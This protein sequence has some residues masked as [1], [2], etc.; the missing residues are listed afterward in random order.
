MDLKNW[1]TSL[2]GL[3]MALPQIL[4]LLGMAL[5]T[6]IMQVLTALGALLLYFAKDKNVTGGG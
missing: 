6:P 2:A 4:P 5:P 3:L 1:K